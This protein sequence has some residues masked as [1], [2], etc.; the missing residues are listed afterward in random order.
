MQANL[1]IDSITRHIQLSATEQEHFLSLLKP[2]TFKRKQLLL[3]EGQV[4]KQSTFVIKGCL[5]GFTVD[6]NGLEHVLSFAPVGW[7]IADMYSLLAQKPGILNIET[8]DETDVLLL[9]KTDQEKLYLDIPQ[10]ERFF[11]VITENS[12]V[13]AQQRLMDSLSLT[14]EERYHNFCRRYPTLIYTLPKKQIASYI[15]V[16]P[17]FFSRM[18]HKLVMK[19]K[20]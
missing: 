18:Q 11:R 16:T 10:F 6:H 8:Q 17:E 9:S 15:G 20:K 3:Q 13:S 7:W 5:R 14:A 19:D 4:C 1:I 2:K 12:L